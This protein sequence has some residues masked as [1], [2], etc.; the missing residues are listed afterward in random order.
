MP[1]PYKTTN[2]MTKH[3]T[4]SERA[5]RERAERS[6]SAGKRVTLK[7]PEWLNEEAKK[8]FDTTKR[9]MK[10]FEVLEAVDV[11]V[12]ALYSDAV[13]RYQRLICIA[14][15]EDD[16]R[17]ASKAQSWSRL[18]LSYAEK[19]GITATGRARLARRKAEEKPVDDMESLLSEVT[20]FVNSDQ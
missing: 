11:D 19:L 7:A 17:A 4:K 10:Q 5:A 6:L 2:N 8:V 1:A 14:D 13:A 9:R 18:A 16:Y 3:L 20:E 15:S 12:L